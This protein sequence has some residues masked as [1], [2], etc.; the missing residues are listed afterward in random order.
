MRR[1]Y[2][3][4]IAKRIASGIAKRIAQRNAGELCPKQC[5][6]AMHVRTYVLTKNYSPWD[7]FL[8]LRIAR[9]KNAD[10]PRIWPR[11]ARF[12]L[13]PLADPSLSPSLEASFHA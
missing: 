2:A 1:A 8:T 11:P 3:S 5:S 6:S 9:E 10:F 4:R 12:A 13:S 7:C